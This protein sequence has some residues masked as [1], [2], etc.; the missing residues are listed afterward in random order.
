MTSIIFDCLNLFLPLHR[1]VFFVFRPS[2]FIQTN[3]QSTMKLQK[4]STLW[5]SAFKGLG[6]QSS[7]SLYNRLQ[8][9]FCQHQIQ[10]NGF[11]CTVV[12]IKTFE[13]IL[14][15]CASNI[16]LHRCFYS[17]YTATAHALHFNDFYHL[18]HNWWAFLAWAASGWINLGH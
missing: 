14:D 4:Q 12:N 3:L 16:Y 17:L 7:T 5:I 1:L 15:T 11:L 10:T 6:P 18:K 8:K 13:Q 9:S 2:T